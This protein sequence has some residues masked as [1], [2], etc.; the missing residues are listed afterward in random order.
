[1]PT[2]IELDDVTLVYEERNPDSRDS[3]TAVVFVHGLGG[4]SYSWWAQLAA[5][6]AQGHRGIAYD[7]RGAGRSTKPGGP[8]SVELWAEDL[9]RVLDH[10]RVDAAILIGHSV[11]CMVVEHAAVR[12]GDRVR[13]L[14]MLGG[15]LRW[16]PEAG[17]VFEQR[18]KLAREGRMDEIAHTVAQTGL[19]E[20]CRDTN[21]ALLGLFL[22]LIASNDPGAYADWSAATAAAHMIEPGRVACP[23]LAAC[24]ELD[25]VTP[26]AFAEAIAAEIPA[27]RTATI[28]GAAHWCHIEAPADVSALLLEFVDEIAT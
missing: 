3:G 6:E 26:P 5:C 2:A 1:M 7:Q 8:Y 23:A 4:S 21:P 27:G 25:P 24:G 13:G 19:S 20:S 16:R 11:G 22:E 15:A 28:E 10:L 18:V 14:A 9:E 12:L 17:P